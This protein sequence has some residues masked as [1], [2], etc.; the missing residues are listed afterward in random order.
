[1]SAPPAPGLDRRQDVAVWLL[2]GAAVIT[3]VVVLL[4]LLSI[5]P[6]VAAASSGPGADSATVVYVGIGIG[7]VLAFELA[8]AVLLVVFARLA[9][10]GV[11]WARVGLVVLAVLTLLQFSEGAL[12]LGL[13]RLLLAAAGTLLLVLPATRRS[14]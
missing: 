1:V 12:V 9:R 8:E 6:T 10:R 11:R 13:L 7:L 3:A 5:A 4:G 14:P 2:L